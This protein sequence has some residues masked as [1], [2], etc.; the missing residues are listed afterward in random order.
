LLARTL[1]LGGFGIVGWIWRVGYINDLVRKLRRVGEVNG[2]SGGLG[3]I[4]YV[5]YLDSMLEN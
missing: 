3:G 2:T 1:L 4:F 5:D